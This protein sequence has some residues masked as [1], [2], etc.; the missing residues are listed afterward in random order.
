MLERAPVPD[1]S[2]TRGLPNGSKPAQKTG[3][4]CAAMG[5][6]TDFRICNCRQYCPTAT[7]GPERKTQNVD[8]KMAVD[9]LRSLRFLC[10]KTLLRDRPIVHH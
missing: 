7:E 9:Y 4:S 10:S 5:S 3:R 2:G 6:A 1:A 8:L